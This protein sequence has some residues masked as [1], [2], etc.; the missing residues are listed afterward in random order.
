MIRTWYQ[1]FFEARS[2]RTVRVQSAGW[3]RWIRRL[4]LLA[5][6][7]FI[8]LSV[9][10]FVVRKHYI[11]AAAYVQWRISKPVVAATAPKHLMFF[12]T[13]HFEPK[14]EMERFAR[15]ERDFPALSQRHRD[16]S[17][18]TFQMTWFYPGEQKIDSNLAGLK[19]LVEAGYGEVE[20]HHHHR[21]EKSYRALERGFED[22]IRH[23]QR[24]GFLRTINGQTRFGFIHGNFGL[25]N[26]KGSEWCGVAEELKLLRSL[27]AYAEFSFP[28]MWESSQPP[29]V[30]RIYEAADD[31]EPKSYARAFPFQAAPSSRLPMFTGPLVVFPVLDPRRSFYRIEDGNIHPSVPSSARRV[32]MW[33]WS[34]IHVPQRPEWVFVKVWGHAA[35]SDE[36]TNDVLSGSF[37]RALTHL[38]KEY[39]DR[40]RYT[41][42]YVTAREAYNVARAAAA[43]KSGDPKQYYDYEVPPYAAA[44]RR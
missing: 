8:G 19:R 4:L 26:A 32:D 25:D 44:A 15:W 6:T 28:A 7:A 42:H 29:V 24:F 16:H 13:D 34:D 22:A 39:N 17:G 3:R 1:E 35:S 10:R 12:Y 11:W 37:D 30:N 31:E 33:V 2:T 18:R 36:E 43:G 5:L 23:M 38:E 20:F 27:G 9:V 41:L 14:F 21:N 40:K